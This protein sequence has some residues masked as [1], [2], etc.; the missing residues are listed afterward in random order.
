M[1]RKRSIPHTRA[2]VDGRTER[3]GAAAGAQVV[4]ALLQMTILFMYVII[5]IYNVQVDE[6]RLQRYKN[7]PSTS[8]YRGVTLA[9]GDALRY[10]VQVG[11]ARGC[12]RRGARAAGMWVRACLCFMFDS[13]VDV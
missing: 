3:Q 2:R 1:G 7:M 6:W 10:L 5:I 12:V 13:R 8:R 4:A 11:S 9:R